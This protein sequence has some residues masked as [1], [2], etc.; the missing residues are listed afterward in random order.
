MQVHLMNVNFMYMQCT[1]LTARPQVRFDKLIIFEILH[2][3][4]T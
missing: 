3:L 1:C 4:Y 2:E